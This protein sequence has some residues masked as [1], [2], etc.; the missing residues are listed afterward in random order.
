MYYCFVKEDL[1]KLPGSDPFLI[2]ARYAEML[3]KLCCC[4]LYR[5]TI[6]DQKEKPVDISGQQ[7]FLRA[8]CDSAR[9]AIKLLRDNG[10]ILVEETSDIDKIERWETLK[11]TRRPVYQITYGNIIYD[12]YTDEVCRFLASTPQLFLKT[13]KKGFS[14]ELTVNV[15]LDKPHKFRELLRSRLRNEDEELL[16]SERLQVRRDSLGKREARHFIRN[17]KLANSSR[18]LHSVRHAVP[19]SLD[20]K[21][22]ELV[23]QIAARKDFPKDY[24]LDTGE[25][26]KN[27][28]VFCDLVELNPVTSSLCYVNNSIFEETVP[29]IRKLST[30]ARMGVEYCYDALEHGECYV[31]DRCAQTDY[32]YLKEEHY[33]F[34]DA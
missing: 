26:E 24:V 15:L 17:G 9:Q 25:F 28:E 13:R 4:C 34:S 22:R 20:E 18:A 30:K 14:A 3:G 19:R 29:E 12:A 10:A 5:N 7:V 11:L 27:G 2:Q 8:S 16:I 32:T 31:W 33:I 6:T 1:E 23:A 21:A